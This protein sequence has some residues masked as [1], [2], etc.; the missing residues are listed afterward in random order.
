MP[1]L[2]VI[3]CVNLNRGRIGCGGMEPQ[4][5]VI[6]EM[7]RSWVRIEKLLWISDYDFVWAKEPKEI[8]DLVPIGDT[9][10]FSAVYKAWDKKLGNQV[11][12]KIIKN[13]L[14]YEK[15]KY[16]YIDTE[17]AASN[18]LNIYPK[19]HI[20]ANFIDTSRL[21]FKYIKF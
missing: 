4:I 2:M 19:E 11:A 8:N 3:D 14:I 7:R 17:F 1:R 13:Q 12:L 10:G 21:K 5:S 6:E 15:S 18:K 20:F 16:L 9:S